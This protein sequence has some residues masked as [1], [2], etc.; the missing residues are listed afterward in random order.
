[1]NATRHSRDRLRRAFVAFALLA[2]W[3]SPHA[4]PG[5]PSAVW[6][7]GQGEMDGRAVTIRWRDAPQDAGVRA[8]HAS[9]VDV[10]WRF[11][12]DKDGKVPVAEVERSLDFETDLEQRIKPHDLAI[13]VAS[14]TDDDKRVWLYYVG[15]G[16]AFAALLDDMKHDDPT[17]PIRYESHADREWQALQ[18]VL[19]AVKE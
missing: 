19:G 14:V 3:T 7:V 1:M 16:D 13:S 9:R 10:T 2:A 11:H 6:V 8:A 4:A 17:L 15:N 18:N 12:R 5:N